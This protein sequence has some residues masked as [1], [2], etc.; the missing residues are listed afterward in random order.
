MTRVIDQDLKEEIDIVKKN[1]LKIMNQDPD[2]LLDQEVLFRETKVL[3]RFLYELVS[4]DLNIKSF[5]IKSASFD[6]KS[7]IKENGKTFMA[8]KS[9]YFLD[10]ETKEPYTEGFASL[11]NGKYIT[12]TQTKELKAYVDGYE[13]TL[14]K[15]KQSEDSII[16]SYAKQKGL[17]IEELMLKRNLE[18]IKEKSIIKI[19]NCEPVQYV[20]LNGFEKDMRNREE[21]VKM[22]YIVE[23]TKKR[24]FK[25]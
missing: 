2:D 25:R 21:F 10:G 4:D 22:R 3:P 7:E 8:F 17:S 20:N 1:I 12:N 19:L 14:N 16:E 5:G 18:N 13:E 11:M 9:G 23:K 24:S 15:Y 6:L